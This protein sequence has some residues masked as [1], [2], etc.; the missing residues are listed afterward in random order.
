M[1]ERGLRPTY[2]QVIEFYLKDDVSDVL[3]ELSN[4][5]PLR[6]FY[7]T[8]MDFTTRGAKA[9]SIRLHC[10]ASRQEFCDAIRAA[11][12]RPSSRSSACKRASTGGAGPTT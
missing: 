5:R 6:F 7:H 10:L 1:N 11:A 2:E 9:A 4:T 8:D 3:W 12:R